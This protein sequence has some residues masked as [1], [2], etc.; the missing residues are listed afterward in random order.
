[1]K[2]L[3][4]LFVLLTIMLQAQENN[5]P[6]VN[7]ADFKA[8]GAHIQRTMG[9]LQNSTAEH[10]NTVR[11]MFYGQSITK[12]DWWKD[13]VIDLKKRFPNAD[14][15]AVNPA[16]GGFASNLLVTTT[17]MDV[18]PFYPDLVIFH[19]YG[20]HF[21]YEEIIADIRKNTTAE[22]ALQTDHC[23][24]GDD[25]AKTDTG[26][27]AFMN[28]QHIPAVAKKYNCAIFDVR[29]GW[30][31]YLLDNKLPQG[32]LLMD[33]T[34]LNKS[35]CF[36]MSELVKRELVAVPEMK[37]DFTNTMVKEIPVKFID[38][39]SCIEF[40]G[41]RVELIFDKVD[42]PAEL[43][44]LVDDKKPSEIASCYTFTRPNEGPGVDWPWTVS[45]PYRINSNTLPVAE[46]WKLTITE[47]NKDD[48]KYKLSGSVT[49]DDGE[50]NSKDKFISKS[51]RVVIDPQYW[52]KNTGGKT[53]SLLKPDYEI[54]FK[55]VL[56]GND[57]VKMPEMPD[58]TIQ[59]TTVLASNLSNE[60]HTLILQVKEGTTPP[61]KAIKVYAPPVK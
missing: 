36:L 5:F 47:G 3:V 43:S 34:H 15:I 1:M 13:V 58:T 30:K 54:K 24:G 52:W 39:K 18:Y 16:I 53:E 11:I 55:S 8:S 32:D 51:G 20:N 2:H 56:I 42:N 31:K 60:E 22:V 44:V 28:G 25:P 59:Y 10:K 35:G 14:I 23:G 6:E 4:Y 12:Q 29:T 17:P 21:K 46:D 37:D 33:G 41:N 45:T 7:L 19:V 49:G 40:T 50:G 9:L 27:T 26:W 48:F 38:G 61:V 57:T